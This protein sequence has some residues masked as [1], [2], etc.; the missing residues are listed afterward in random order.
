M[1]QQ[2]IDIAQNIDKLF[3]L[4]E[5]DV[6]IYKLKSEKVRK[7][8]DVAQLRQQQEQEKKLFDE[9]KGHLQEIQVKRK[10]KEVELGTK[11]AEVKK[12][13]TQL[14]QLKTN[15]EYEAMQREIKGI[16]ADASALE[17]EILKL[18]D[19]TE[20]AEKASKEEEKTI[21]QKHQEIDSQIKIIEQE[22]KAIEAE[23]VEKQEK[24]KQLA[25]EVN[26]K[27]LGKYEKI[28]RGKDGLA[29]VPVVNNT[30]GGCFMQLPP[31]VINEIKLKHEIIYCHLCSRILFDRS[32]HQ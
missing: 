9:G 3:K 20:Q 31:Q 23:L 13:N 29:M 28:L 27:I 25:A 8:Q 18:M 6:V 1:T 16:Q 26:P 19:E 15:K 17:D 32:P 5:A 10:H 4:Q 14:L 11:E 2:K 22:I 7:P 21:Q 24:R 30:C 12:L